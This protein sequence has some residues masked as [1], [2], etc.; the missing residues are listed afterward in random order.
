MGLSVLTEPCFVDA[1]IFLFTIWSD[2]LY[3]LSCKEFLNRVEAGELKGI[4]L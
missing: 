2:D 1:N 3:G 4:P